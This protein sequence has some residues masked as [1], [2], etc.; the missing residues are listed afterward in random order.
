MLR[1]SSASV[2][3]LLRGAAAACKIR[4]QPNLSQVCS[5]FATGPRQED[6]TFYEIRTYDIKPGKAKDFL[7]LVSRDINARLAH[8]EM[9]GFWTAELGAMNKALHIW[10][11][12]SFA[13]RTAVR[14]ALLDNKRWQETLSELLPLVTKQHAEIAYLVPW[15]TLGTPPKQGVYELVTYQMKP[16]GPA[17]WGR[18]FKTTVDAHA[19]KNYAKLIGVFHTEYGLLNTVHVLWWYEDPDSRATGRHIAHE[20]ARVVAAVRENVQFLESQQNMLLIPAP[21][22]PLK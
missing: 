3:G 11:Y 16:G 9:I 13:H 2:L 6:G 1:S 10:K 17:L 20:D 5:P 4:A 7:E 14:K 15:C 12:D 21:F 19:S 8:S 22:S 18:T